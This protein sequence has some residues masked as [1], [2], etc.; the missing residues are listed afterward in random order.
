MQYMYHLFMIIVKHLSLQKCSFLLFNTLFWGGMGV[1]GCNGGGGGINFRYEHILQQ[2]Q[3]ARYEFWKWNHKTQHS[4][5]HRQTD[6][7]KP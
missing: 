6:K 7:T 4:P 5:T 1:K 3:C 2:L